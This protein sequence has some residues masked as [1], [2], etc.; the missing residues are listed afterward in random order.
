MCYHGSGHNAPDKD[1][2]Q[3]LT[4]YLIFASAFFEYVKALL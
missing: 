1:V 4:A 2:I 3:L